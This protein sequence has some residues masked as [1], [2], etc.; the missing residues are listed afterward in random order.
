M[1]TEMA[2]ELGVWIPRSLSWIEGVIEPP[3]DL[4]PR[5]WN[6][7]CSQKELNP[8]YFRFEAECHSPLGDANK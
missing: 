4:L 3:G 8:H 1:V 6:D 2:H 5:P 7:W